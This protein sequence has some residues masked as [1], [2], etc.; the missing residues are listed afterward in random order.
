MMFWHSGSDC[1]C[2]MY[3]PIDDVWSEAV[4]GMMMPHERE[5]H[6]MV[7]VGTSRIFVLAG[8]L[9]VFEWMIHLITNCAHILSL[10]LL[11]IFKARLKVL[12]WYVAIRL[13]NWYINN[14]GI[15]IDLSVQ[16]KC[17]DAFRAAVRS[18]FC[19][20]SDSLIMLLTT[21][22]VRMKTLGFVVLRAPC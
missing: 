6:N 15:C 14:D 22:T 8:R 11:K 10:E 21:K 12:C 19:L 16:Q 13:L 9:P 18:T 3:D 17:L 20:F 4:E 1:C 5:K 2:R 7:S